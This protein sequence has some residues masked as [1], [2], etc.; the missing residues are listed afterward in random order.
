MVVIKREIIHGEN[1]TSTLCDLIRM[2]LTMSIL[3]PCLSLAGIK[4]NSK[5]LTQRLLIVMLT[6]SQKLAYTDEN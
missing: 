1:P 5:R 6:N 3:P 2:I 4:D